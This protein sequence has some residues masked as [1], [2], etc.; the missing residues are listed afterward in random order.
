MNLYI[1]RALRFNLARFGAVRFA[2]LAFARLDFAPAALSTIR[3]T[4]SVSKNFLNWTMRPS[5]M[6]DVMR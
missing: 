1:T 3:P 2:P 6:R 4:S 5:P